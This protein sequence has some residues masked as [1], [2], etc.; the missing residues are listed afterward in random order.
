MTYTPPR[1]GTILIPS[2][3]IRD[4]DRLHLFVIC[5]DPCADGKQ[6]IVPVSSK[7]ND[8]CDLT[9]VLQPHEHSFLKHESFVFYKRA[10]I[11]AHQALIN[12]VTQNTFIPHD[13]MNGQT[14]LRI[15]N[16]ICRSLETPRKIKLYIKCKD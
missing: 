4:P 2:G 9:C 15:Y 1:K 14:F 7:I 16:G 3:P 12:G 6:L 10:R 5:T 11:E 8:R 13:N